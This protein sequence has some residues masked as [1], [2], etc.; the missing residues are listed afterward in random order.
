MACVLAPHNEG[1]LKNVTINHKTLT[2]GERKMKLKDITKTILEKVATEL[3]KVMD[4]KPVIATGSKIK[5]EAIQADVIDA[6]GDP[7]DGLKPADKITA[8]TRE[9]LT[10]L[11]VDVPKAASG[12]KAT[13]GN[14]VKKPRYNRI[15]SVLEALSDMGKDADKTEVATAANG[16]YIDHAGKDN[17]AE[18]K[19]AT[20]MVFQVMA[21][22]KEHKVKV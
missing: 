2:K 12:K 16:F 10:L 17:L 8:Q 14:K 11:G 22:I 7:E 15:S 9:V 4:L 19:W 5:K 21:G 13:T 20:N 18:S 6:A 3:N 1:G